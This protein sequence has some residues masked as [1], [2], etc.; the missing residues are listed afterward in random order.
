M[1]NLGRTV[2]LFLH[3][4][5]QCRIQNDWFHWSVSSKNSRMELNNSSTFQG[6]YAVFKAQTK[7]KHFSRQGLKFKHF[8]SC[9]SP[10]SLR[11]RRLHHLFVLFKPLRYP[12]RGRH[13]V[14]ER[15]LVQPGHSVRNLCITQVQQRGPGRSLSLGKVDL[16]R[17]LGRSDS[18]P[19]D[20]IL[21]FRDLLAVTL[22]ILVLRKCSLGIHVQRCIE[23]E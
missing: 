1:H 15:R 7:F 22:S 5:W 16:A 10:W 18:L 17:S 2:V 21:R 23:V 14:L 6:F 13:G 9:C 20:F 19:E 4:E 11:Q 3:I 8:S 12:C